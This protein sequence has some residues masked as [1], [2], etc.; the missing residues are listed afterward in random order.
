MG[1]TH[2]ARP[3]KN[4]RSAS[5]VNR[6]VWSPVFVDG[7]CYV[8]GHGPFSWQREVMATCSTGPKFQWFFMD[9]LLT[10]EARH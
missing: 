6:W 2:G 7:I 5:L 9:Y 3:T 8:C 4:R 1:H 10:C